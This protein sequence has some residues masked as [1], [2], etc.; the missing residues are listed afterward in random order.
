[1][2]VVVGAVLIVL[3][4][5]CAFIF[6]AKRRKRRHLVDTYREVE[7]SSERKDT[8]AQM[9]R[10]A[11]IG[12]EPVVHMAEYQEERFELGNNAPSARDHP[13]VPT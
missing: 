8:Y 11:A 4:A 9:G 13:Q 5:T 1:M 6:F 12:G 3:G 7:L 2:G 10:P